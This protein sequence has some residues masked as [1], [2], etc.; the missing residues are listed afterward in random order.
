[1]EQ[2]FME[3]SDTIEFLSYDLRKELEETSEDY[4]VRRSQKMVELFPPSRPIRST[5]PETPI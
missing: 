5:S 1:M 3:L 2:A 4:W